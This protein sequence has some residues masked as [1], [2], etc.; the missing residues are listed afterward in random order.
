MMEIVKRPHAQNF[1]DWAKDKPEVVV[2]TADLTGSC[3]ADAFRSAYPQRYFAMGIAEQNML[4]WA[5]GLAKE[6]F[7][8]YIHTFAVFIYRQAFHQME[9][10]IAYP[11]L[12]VKM[13]GFLPGILTPGGMTHQATDDLAIVRTIPNMT[14]LECGDATEVQS[15]LD[16]A[17][18]V[19]GPVYIR[20]LRGEVPRIFP[21]SE[22]MQLGKSR[23]LSTGND[24][25]IFT[26]GICTEEA[27]RVTKIL[28]E[29]GVG[30]QHV[31]I[32]T[33]KPFDDPAVVEAIE[34]AKFGV[35]SMENHTV[36]GG[37]GTAVAEVIAGQGLKTRL[38]K[39]GLQ[40][41]F[42]HGAS[43]TYLVKKYGLD[44][45][46]L[47]HSIETLMNTSFGINEDELSSVHLTP[48]HSL[49]K[50]EAL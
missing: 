37:L 3:E 29:K 13:M 27:M 43:R 44:A 11:N 48:V 40:D 7:E 15:V 26:S 9:V 35:I 12:P 36:I 2:L 4:S 34:R 14:V 1:V 28:G 39:M 50:V 38:I 5:A 25:T 33:L 17:H 49:A 16:V 24:V 6:G 10:S 45:M 31:H 21:E 47:V 19:Q 46:S 42:A 8:P 32:S 23:V 41:V 20:M 22:P 30:V 18:Q